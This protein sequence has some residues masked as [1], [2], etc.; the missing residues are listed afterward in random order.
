[1]TDNVGYKDL[2]N[3]DYDTGHDSLDDYCLVA[4]LNEILERLNALENKNNE[5]P[6]L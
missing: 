4:L 1:M 5:R 2:F 6:L 3:H